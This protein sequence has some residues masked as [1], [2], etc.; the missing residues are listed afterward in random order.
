VLEASSA[1]TISKAFDE[2]IPQLATVLAR[3]FQVDPA[4]SHLLPDSDDRTERLR[5]FFETELRGVAMPLGLVWTTEEVAGGAIWAPPEAWRVPVTTTVRELPPM[6]RVFGGRLLV[7]LSSRLRMENRHPRKPSHWY[8]AVMG[9]ATEWQGKG[10]GTAL[11]RPA[12]E[13]LDA[14]ETPAYLEA[15]TPRRRALYQRNGFRVTGEF[16]LPF[17]GP[18][19][20]QMWREPVRGTPS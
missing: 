2:D 11:M 15:S 9:V 8:L 3:A 1:G 4:W 14:E 7:A 10:L 5:L 18:P 12:L 19:L 17:G 6:V 13:V 16:N 20:W